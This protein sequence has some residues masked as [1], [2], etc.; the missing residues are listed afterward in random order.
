MKFRKKLRLK[1]FDYTSNHISFIT[2]RVVNGQEIL[3]GIGDSLELTKEGEIVKKQI[4]WL[5]EQYEYVIIHSYVIMPNHVHLL[6]EIDDRKALPN[7]KV[8]SISELIG[9]LKT[10]SCKQIRLTCNPLFQWHK[11]F[12]DRIVRD[13]VAYQ[14][15]LNYIDENPKRWKEK[16]RS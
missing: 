4:V 8:K 6:L 3:S 2:F 11:S 15:I 12:H 14:M 1:D 7:Q 13:E 5:E 9:A 10:T 16:R